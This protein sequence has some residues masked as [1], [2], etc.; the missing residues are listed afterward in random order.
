MV[1][2]LVKSAKPARLPHRSLFAVS[3]G[4]ALG[5]DEPA[6]QKDTPPR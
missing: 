6:D 3:Y 4:H 2:D 5:L 1:G